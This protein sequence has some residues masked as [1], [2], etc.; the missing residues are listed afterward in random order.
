MSQEL[1]TAASPT[2]APAPPRL[3]RVLGLGDLIFYGIVLI[4]PV[5]AVGPFGLANKMSLGHVT[6]TILIALVAMMLTA[7]SYGRMAGLYPAAGSAYTYVGRGLNPHLGFLAGWA[8]FLDY[9]V[10]PIVSIVYGA[11][12]LQRV[13]EALA[14]GF[15]QHFGSAL[16]LTSKPEH[17]AFLIWVILLTALMTFLNLRGIKWTAHA[18]QIMTAAMFLVIAWFVV[19]AVR[20]LWVHQGF[21]GLFSTE[22]FY[23]PRTFNIGAIGTATSLAALTYIGFDGI[24]TLAEDAK[25]PKRTV[26]L[27]IVLVC[28]LI[29]L[30]AF[31]QVYL[32][33]RV[34]PDYSTFK[35]L[36]TAF[37]DVCELVGGK[38]LFH[39]LALIM[40]VACLGSALTGQVGAA[41]ILFGMGRDN[42][43]PR[44]FARLDRRNNPALNI[45]IIGVL[46]L[47]GALLLDYEKAATLINFGAFLAFLGVNAAVLRE[48]VFRPPVGHKR[49]WLFDL[50][51]PVLAFAFCL[52]IWIELPSPAQVVGGI[53]CAVG[54]LYTAI[55]TRGFRNPPKMIDLNV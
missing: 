23:N 9:L 35:D 40:A 54:I 27:S 41:R 26:P 42:A 6:A 51:S 52:W 19:A 46:C 2:E 31:V 20:Y 34:W 7:L 18:N 48:F 47:A 44:F 22:P 38:A 39:A 53:W 15:S 37:F 33:Q 28:L 21:G 1:N 30:C 13:V 3:R 50:I 14:P 29:G 17:A 45:A 55:M 25:E 12:S 43:L 11:L 4:Q 5:G 16:G 49:N 24:T 32:G 8:M 36:D 10:I